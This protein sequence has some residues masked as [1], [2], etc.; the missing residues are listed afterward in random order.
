MLIQS[1]V[2]TRFTGSHRGSRERERESERES[3]RERE[4]ERERG[5]LQIREWGTKEEVGERG[6]RAGDK[7]S[8][9]G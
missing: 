9:G 7:I 3:E 5:S 6:E 4:R 2:A 8:E 1:E